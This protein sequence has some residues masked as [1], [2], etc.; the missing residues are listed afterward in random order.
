MVILKFN[1]L[2]RNKWVWGVFALIVSIAFVAPNGCLYGSDA[3]RAADAFNKCP[4]V[5][6]DAELFEQCDYLVRGKILELNGLS[7]YFDS[8]KTE[9][10]WKVYAALVAFKQAGVAVSDEML[11]DR[12]RMIR[13][14]ADPKTQKF[15][16]KY[17]AAAVEANFRL[18]VHQFERYYRLALMLETGLSA[19]VMDKTALA[20]AEI[21]Q[22]CYDFTD[23]FTVRIATFTEDKSASEKVKITPK[24][25]GAYYNNNK[26]SYVFPD[27]YKVR[28]LKLNPL[29]SNLLAKVTVTDEQIKARYEE[30]KESG[31]Y[32]VT[33]TNDTVTVK[34]LDEVRDRIVVDLK[35]EAAR[36]DLE[37]EIMAAMPENTEKDKTAKFLDEL[38]A[39][40]KMTVQTSDWF[41]FDGNRLPGFLKSV[42][43]EFPNID[44]AEFKEK[45]R[46]LV[47]NDLNIVS[48]A[49]ALWIFQ[50]AGVSEGFEP[51]FDEAT[52][53]FRIPK[54]EDEE[55]ETAE[56][57]KDDAADKVAQAEFDKKMKAIIGPKAL[58]NA[59]AENFK[60][61]VD[62]IIKKGAD[63]VLKASN[64]ST[65]IVFQ[66]CSFT[67]QAFGWENRYR[68]WD[69]SKAGFANA[70]KIVP[71]SRKL[72][73]GGV[74]DFI[75]LS[76]GRAAVVV[77]QD[78]VP[79]TA[80]D[81]E[82]GVMFARGV[83]MMNRSKSVGKAVSQWLEW[84]LKSFGY[85]DDSALEIE[86]TTEKAAE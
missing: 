40:K 24:D 55:N 2:I 29:A 31:I 20:P 78:R 74:S 54:Y 28:Y 38:A 7:E 6:F 17:Y 75:L 84:N 46:D 33:S 51:L 30:N 14:F 4:D 57:K 44:V 3:R 59:R 65:N 86:E 68:E 27:R 66:P 37:E 52:N 70:A 50:S 73:K 81:Y 43:L 72:V 64:V 58:E 16:P 22:E 53:S 12:I 11:S 23:K 47:D 67:K 26:A 83:E 85:K 18:S 49:N 63:E 13:F 45:V 39:K 8:S 15:D 19:V 35:N 9:S 82:R 36:A 80:E 10:T 62:A 77:C 48:T 71:A 21:E 56:V 41:S 25:M 42:Q 1:K 61:T 34:T 32:D 69:F 5:E 79:G 60:A 76:R